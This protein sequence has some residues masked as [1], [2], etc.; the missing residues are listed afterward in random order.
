VVE[1]PLRSSYSVGCPLLRGGIRASLPLLDSGSRSYRTHTSLWPGFNKGAKT[2]PAYLFLTGGA[3]ALD[4][5]YIRN[6]IFRSV[7][8]YYAG[9]PVI[10]DNVTFTNCT[11]VF[12]NN[13]QTKKLALA[14]LGMDRINL[15]TH[16]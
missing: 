11:F 4:D 14:I 5:M 1:A 3:T 6:V 8:V 13:E 12:V 10:L 7:A 16:L 15:A 9:Q 2:G